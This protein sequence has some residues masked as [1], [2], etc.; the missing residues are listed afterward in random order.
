MEILIRFK[1]ASE[2]AEFTD[3][4]DPLLIYCNALIDSIDESS[5][6]SKPNELMSLECVRIAL[7][8]NRLDYLT[9]WVAQQK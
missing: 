7:K 2:Q 6:V 5:K 4:N 8:Y 1:S 9:R 3:Q